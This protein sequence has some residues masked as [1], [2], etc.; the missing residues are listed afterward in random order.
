MVLQTIGYQ[1]L[2]RSKYHSGKNR[3]LE[4]SQV[5]PGELYI[6]RFIL[7]GMRRQDASERFGTALF[8]CTEV[9]NSGDERAITGQL[10][11][12]NEIPVAFRGRQRELLPTTAVDMGGF[13]LRVG[14]LLS[15]EDSI[16]DELEQLFAEDHPAEASELV[17]VPLPVRVRQTE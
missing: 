13:V 2:A 8:Q 17:R 1:E 6:A 16:G 11:D 4:V 9:A 14:Y 10:G 3:A 15:P 12:A 7:L 5:E